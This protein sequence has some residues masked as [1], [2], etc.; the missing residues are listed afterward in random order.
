M[1]QLVLRSPHSVFLG[2]CSGPVAGRNCLLVPRCTRCAPQTHFPMK[3]V[4]LVCLELCE[5]QA[6]YMEICFRSHFWSEVEHQLPLQCLSQSSLLSL[7]MKAV[8]ASLCNTNTS[9]RRDF[10]NQTSLFFNSMKLWKEEAN[11]SANVARAVQPQLPWLQLVRERRRPP[12]YIKDFC[13]TFQL[14]ELKTETHQ[15]YLEV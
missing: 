2:F 3:E 12:C 10:S 15:P 1:N 7:Y 4:H 5:A 6:E 13:Q 14:G 9:M 11:C 8:F